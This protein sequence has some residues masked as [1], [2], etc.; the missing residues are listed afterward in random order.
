[1][2]AV[3]PNIKITVSGASICEKSVGGAEKKGQLLPEHVGAA[4]Y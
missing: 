1:M 2:K 4:D 3:D